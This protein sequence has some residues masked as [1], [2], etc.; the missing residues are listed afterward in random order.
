[1][2]EYMKLK[3]E[4]ACVIDNNTLNNVE[5]LKKYNVE[6]FNKITKK[7]GKLENG[8]LEKRILLYQTRMNEKIYIQ[9]PG[10]ENTEERKDNSK[11]FNSHDFKPVIITGANKVVPDMEFYD[12]FSCIETAICEDN[13]SINKD[14]IYILGSLL[15]RMAYMI[16]Y[17]KASEKYFSYF[18]ENNSNIL[19]ETNTELSWYK[20]ELSN[21]VVSM[22]NSIFKKNIIFKGYEISIEAFLYYLDLIAQNEECKYSE[23]RQTKSQ[24]KWGRINSCSSQMKILEYYLG[25]MT[26]GEVL[27]SFR[28]GVS[29]ITKPEEK[30]WEITGKAILYKRI[31]WG[32]LKKNYRDYLKEID[33]DSVE[34][35]YDYGI[36][37]AWVKIKENHPRIKNDAKLRYKEVIEKNTPMISKI[38]EF[39]REKSILIKEIQEKVIKI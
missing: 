26:I 32:G 15:A 16:D 13:R 38:L 11:K 17:K 19:S 14:G 9:Y 30:I 22:L 29:P 31:N 21:Q 39:D 24:Q 35:L 36:D 34:M 20:L 10:K 27:S 6:S 8:K 12:I 37:N 4:F 1:M 28:S 18:I 23:R 2:K 25:K 5:I 3:S 7:V 33:I